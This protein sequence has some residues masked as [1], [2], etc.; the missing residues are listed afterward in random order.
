[1]DKRIIDINYIYYIIYIDI[2]PLI[3]IS[4]SLSYIYLRGYIRACSNN[5]MFKLKQEENIKDPF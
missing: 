3:L 2:S 4:A 1:M 5:E